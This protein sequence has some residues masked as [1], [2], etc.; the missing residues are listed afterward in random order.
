MTGAP[1]LTWIV[2][3]PLLG[4]LLLTFLPSGRRGL[5]RNAAL[6]IT[7]A[8]F[9]L[10]VV[11]WRWFVPEAPG[12][13]FEEARPWIT[14]FGITYHLGVDG[15]ALLMVALTAL[16]TF[17]AV[18]GATDG[19]KDRMKEFL[20]FL[21]LLETGMQ[22]VFLS[23]DLFLFYVFWEAMLVPM[24]LLIGVW[25]GPRR[26][27]ATVKFFLYTMAGSV[28]M[29]LAILTLVL[30]HRNATGVLS[31]DLA[32]LLGASLPFRTQSLLF[33]AFALAFAIK[34]PLFPFHTWLPDAHVEAP[35]AGSVLLAGI[36]LKMGVFGFLRFGIPLFPDAAFASIPILSVLALIG[37]V[38]GALVSLV[39][40]DLKKLVAY[41]SVSH[42]GFVMLGIFAMNP[43]GMAGGILQM[44]NHGISTGALFLCVGMLYER[45]HSR[46]IADFGGVTKSMPLF[47]VLFLL[48]TLSSV[49][50]P[51]M[52][53]FVGEFLIL[54][55]TFRRHMP[56][57]AIAV[58]G[59]VF[60]AAYLLWMIRRVMFGPVRHAEV[61]AFRDLRPAEAWALIPLIALA[62]W[63]GI[64]PKPFLSRTERAAAG[65]LARMH[66]AEMVSA[67]GPAATP[68]A[69]VGRAV[70]SGA[71]AARR[72][73]PEATAGVVP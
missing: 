21:L 47:A 65:I 10:T 64:Y 50:L 13:Q 34:V 70:A 54:L 56:F 32:D 2:F 67:R 52:N 46:M 23:L 42:L 7:L 41:S 35:T 44:V 17:L 5:L 53:G 59:V 60:A 38:Y 25:G 12:M 19:V 72:G 33:A 40:P 4:G 30:L 55:G 58:T 39:Q 69:G 68:P 3:L 15:I 27:Y 1:I 61:A 16:L 36:L 22:G 24:Y 71:P 11:L 26:V 66:A 45:R 6:A 43:E 73:D 49:G 31:F 29:F 37:I 8:E 14:A 20:L 57:A 18:L 51:G 28:L 63:I 48:V 9:L 62:L